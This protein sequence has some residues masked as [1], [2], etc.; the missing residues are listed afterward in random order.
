M[1]EG[2]EV[3]CIVNGQFAQNCY[4]LADTESGAAA[5]VDP[6]EEHGRILAEV[7]RR[8][9]RIEQIWLTHAHIDHIL[10]LAAVKRATG[11]PVWLHPDDLPL[12]ASLPQQA[13][14]M[15]VRAEAAP[16]PEHG[17]AHGMTLALGG[18]RF[19]VRH[20]P[21]HSPGSVVLVGDGLVIAGDALFAGSV[22]RVDLPGGDGPTLIRSI[23]EQLLTLDDATVV[24]SGHGP[25]TSIGAERRTNPFLNGTV[26]LV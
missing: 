25:A 20:T 3:V 7:A 10:G 8:G 2:L 17:L 26:S 15:G 9:W 21:G 19:E 24:H 14:W 12:Y 5:M 4:L 23:R 11:A 13:A 6:G 1:S 18:H 22:G 16:A